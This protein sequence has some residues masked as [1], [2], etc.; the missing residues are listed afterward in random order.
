MG[1]VNDV[2]LL[3]ARWW[4][5]TAR[6]CAPWVVCLLVA[7][8][9]ATTDAADGGAPSAPSPAKVAQVVKETE[10][11]TI[12]LTAKA[13]ER[14][15][16]KLAA[17]ERK[18]V[19]ATRL[20]G[21]EMVIPPGREVTAS[22]PL[23]GRVQSTAFP[24]AGQG[25]KKDQ[26]L[27]V[28]QPA[29]TASER[30]RLRESQIEAAGDV[31]QL[32]AQASATAIAL[33]RGQEL[34]RS[35]TG[36]QRALDEA[37]AAN[38]VAEA[39]LKAAEIRAEMLSKVQESDLE[40]K[41][42]TLQVQAPIDGVLTEIHVTAGQWVAGGA[43]LF[44]V[45][46]HERLWVRVPVPV[47]ELPQLEAH[48]EAQLGPLRGGSAPVLPPARPVVAPPTANAGAATADL[49]Y[50]VQNGGATLRPGQRVGVTVAL[51]GE[52]ECLVV[53]WA[54]VLYD[55][56]GG[57]WVYE[58]TE[59]RTYVRRRVQVARLSGT[60]AVL[61]SG[62]KPGARIVTDGAAELFGTEFGI[63]K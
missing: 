20:L 30:V 17:A 34:L 12:T 11:N 36:S 10:L 18:K 35:G 42:A 48:K 53:P 24:A 32:R 21:G 4:H 61:A 1:H 50:E 27:L 63:G 59:P 15:G 2:A 40:G 38:S 62:P 52:T 9:P 19:P 16:I 31:A 33:K 39:R 23:S 26:V 56:H 55:I 41:A 46:N 7:A 14:L 6:C 13:E 44:H 29:L 37:Q 8:A 43:P 5:R 57:Q 3:C 25:V 22:A 47:D 49:Y 45:V 58:N 51:R 54:A 60:D 28:F